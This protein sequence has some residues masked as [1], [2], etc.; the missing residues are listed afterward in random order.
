MPDL[1]HIGFAAR[2]LP[3][4]LEAFSELGFH[5]TTPAELLGVDPA[6][7][8]PSSLGQTSAHIVL[9]QTYIELTAVPDPSSVNHLQPYL[10]RYEGLQILALREADLETA[11]ARIGASGLVVT[12]VKTARRRISYG[13]RHGD[14]CFNWF[15]LDPDHSPEGL[16]C[17]VTNETPELVFQPEV[18]RHPNGAVDV[19]GVVICTA[20]PREMASRY[21]SVLGPPAE[22]HDDRALFA[23]GNSTIT[24]FTP[25]V[26][27]AEW[28][29]LEVPAVP[30]L[31][32]LE[33]A[34]APA[35]ENRS[36]VLMPPV[37]AFID[38]IAV[39]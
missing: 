12:P 36:L 6:T 32:G 29:T 1:D 34:T 4:L 19:T 11:H 35:T 24:V 14:A 10:Q 22:I 38:M 31:V 13:Q 26:L 15:M 39:S 8:R 5:I 23:L 16:V 33:V 7:G 37:N 3:P 30:A 27:N 9:A 17:F 20:E 21:T 2:D 25:E 28:P 18:Q